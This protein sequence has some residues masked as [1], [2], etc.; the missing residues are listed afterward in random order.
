MRGDTATMPQIGANGLATNTRN[1]NY[2][3]TNRHIH[4]HTH[5]YNQLIFA[6]SQPLQHTEQ[7]LQKLPDEMQV[8]V[9]QSKQFESVVAKLHKQVPDMRAK[10]A[11]TSTTPTTTTITSSTKTTIIDDNVSIATPLVDTLS[12]LNNEE[13]KKTPQVLSALST[14][15]IDNNRR[16]EDG[17]RTLI[18]NQLNLIEQLQLENANLRNERDHLHLE[19][20][21]LKFQLQM[22]R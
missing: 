17:K 21:E 7:I 1:G 16:E 22:I 10:I 5:N 2:L 9:V 6:R 18:K 4:N 20:E 13:I 8:K 15:L 3:H 12:S 11:V 14:K 19:N